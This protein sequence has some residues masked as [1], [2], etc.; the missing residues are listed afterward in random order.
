MMACGVRYRQVI[1]SIHVSCTGPLHKTLG[2]SITGPLGEGLWRVEGQGKQGRLLEYGMDF[3][4]Q[5]HGHV[6]YLVGITLT[7]RFS[8]KRKRRTPD[9]ARRF[10]SLSK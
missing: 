10:P 8:K 2:G 6:A 3:A 5:R 4:V 1:Q 7:G 9:A